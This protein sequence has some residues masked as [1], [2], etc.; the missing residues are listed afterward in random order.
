MLSKI[1]VAQTI[2]R[3]VYVKLKIPLWYK[4]KKAKNFE[5]FNVI[6]ITNGQFTDQSDN[7]FLYSMTKKKKKIQKSLSIAYFLF[8]CS[9]LRELLLI[10]FSLF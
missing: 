5:L 3:A 9:F 2:E 7:V 6:I 4:L 8:K 10:I 1:C